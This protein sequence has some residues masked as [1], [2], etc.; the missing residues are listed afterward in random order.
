MKRPEDLTLKDNEEYVLLEYS[1]CAI[2]L[3]ILCVYICII[4][5]YI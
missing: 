3:I 5:I 1:V 2:L 4:Y